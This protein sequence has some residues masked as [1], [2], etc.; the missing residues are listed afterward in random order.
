[1]RASLRATFSN[2][3]GKPTVTK[4]V[5][6]AETLVANNAVPYQ[7]LIAGKHERQGDQ[8][9]R[10]EFRRLG[11]VEG[12]TSTNGTVGVVAKERTN[13]PVCPSFLVGR[14]DARSTIDISWPRR[15]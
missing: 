3:T 12:E 13:E 2:S 1:M 7:E 14:P 8:Q 9:N 5:P 11:P 10:R 15:S 4:N 6:V